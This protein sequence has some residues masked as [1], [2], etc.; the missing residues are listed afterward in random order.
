ML[1][2]V[3]VK[4]LAHLRGRPV[5]WSQICYSLTYSNGGLD[6]DYGSFWWRCFYLVNELTDAERREKPD[7]LAELT[8]ESHWADPAPRARSTI[9]RFRFPPQDHTVKLGTNPHDPE[10]QGSVGTV[11]HLDDEEGVIDIRCGSNRPSPDARSLIPYDFFNPR[12]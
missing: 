4:E 12:P 2:N 6:V 9:Y 5:F 10:T 1:P 7:A 8:P 3:L 11:F